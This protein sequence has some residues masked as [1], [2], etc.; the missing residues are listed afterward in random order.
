[1]PERSCG[2]PTGTDENNLVVDS[3][4]NEQRGRGART[5]RAGDS[6]YSSTGNSCTSVYRLSQSPGLEGRE[7]RLEDATLQV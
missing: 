7:T 3:G 4:E 5:P 1:M 2:A 6:E